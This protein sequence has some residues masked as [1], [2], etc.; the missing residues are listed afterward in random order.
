MMIIERMRAWW[1]QR[2]VPKALA[3]RLQVRIEDLEWAVKSNRQRH[4]EAMSALGSQLGAARQ[5]H[6]ADLSRRIVWLEALGRI[7][8]VHDEQ[9]KT[10]ADLLKVHGL[11]GCRLDALA[12]EIWPVTAGSAAE[13]GLRSATDEPEHPCAGA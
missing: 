8:Q 10:L 2:W 12:E 3:D 7:R 4:E 6:R 5:K 1:R 9:G 13:R 11:V